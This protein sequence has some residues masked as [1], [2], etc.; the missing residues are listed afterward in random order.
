ME[1]I[2]NKHIEIEKAF[3]NYNSALEKT[4]KRRE[5]WNSDAKPK[6]IATLE[7]IVK[8][9]GF[10]WAVQRLES[11]QNLETINIKIHSQNSGIIE[12]TNDENTGKITKRK[13]YIKHGG[14]LAF[15]Q[16]FNGKVNVI[17]SHPS[18]ESW[19]DKRPTSFLGTHGPNE[20]TEDLIANYVIKFLDLMTEFESLESQK[21][22]FL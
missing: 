3:N 1:H 19:V 12:L 18:I 22:G 14:Y 4:I 2:L 21:I 11:T 20:I 15:C 13:A 10:S 5:L 6:L 7:K 16:M 8:E 9:F 17:V